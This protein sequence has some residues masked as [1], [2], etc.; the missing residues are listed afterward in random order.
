VLS[1]VAFIFAHRGLRRP[2]RSGY[3]VRI[4]R[5]RDDVVVSPLLGPGQLCER[6]WLQRRAA[7]A[8]PEALIGETDDQDLISAFGRRL[9]GAEAPSDPLQRAEL[10]RA[11]WQRRDNAPRTQA[12]GT[13]RP[14]RATQGG[15]TSHT[16]GGETSQSTRATQ[17]G[18]VPRLTRITPG[19]YARAEPVLPLPTCGICWEQ[20]GRLRQMDLTHLVGETAGIVNAIQEI[21]ALEG[22]PAFPRVVVTR[23]TNVCL[24]P[25]RAYGS[26]ASGKGVT[27]SIA[28]RSAVAETLERYAASVAPTDLV[29]AAVEELDKPVVPTRLTG[30]ER[31]QALAAGYDDK[32]ELAWVRARPAK[33]TGEAR[34]VPASAIY[35]NL[36]P[37]QRRRVPVPMTTSGLACRPNLADAVAAGL[38]EVIERHEFFAV[39]YGLKPAAN[40]E[41]GAAIPKEAARDFYRHDLEL[42]VNILGEHSGVVVASASCWP[43]HRVP[44]RPSF[45]LGLGT[46]GSVKT[47][48]AGAVL[49]AAQVYR[50]LTWALRNAAMRERMELLVAGVVQPG[51]PYD[52]GLLYARRPPEDVPAPFGL[53]L[54]LARRHRAP[55]ERT[56]TALGP[57]LYVDIT[58]ADVLEAS[59]WRVV[60]VVVPDAIPYHYGTDMIPWQRL[61]LPSESLVPLD[62]AHPLS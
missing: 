29:M 48:A 39:W 36:P 42:R 43:I 4:E 33:P 27:R 45:V 28:C 51:E 41:A 1:D 30:A 13:P 23:L 60:R 62:A 61:H 10:A 19:G 9:A 18:E 24:N 40:V 16:Q 31:G 55:R 49:E 22:E 32:G 59:G 14:T 46:G 58:P 56:A 7:A 21:P 34:W 37:A 25:R 53:G 12:C 54:P 8:D 2:P 20:L 57:A 5:E 6:C 38:A 17:G 50:G 11:L 15:E 52:H 26:G 3:T 47:A 35:L 44:S